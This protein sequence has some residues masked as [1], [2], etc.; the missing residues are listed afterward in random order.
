M[1]A[2][3]G[4]LAFAR[5]TAYSRPL[6][7]WRYVLERKPVAFEATVRRLM[8]ETSVADIFIE[9]SPWEDSTSAR[10]HRRWLEAVRTWY[11]LPDEPGALDELAYLFFDDV[12]EHEDGERTVYAD[13]PFTGQPGMF[14]NVH[15]VGHGVLTVAGVSHSVHPGDAYLLNPAIKHSWANR[16][17]ARCKAVSMVVPQELVAGLLATSSSAQACQFA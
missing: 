12:P 13:G 3:S 16:H 17:T 10:Y 2:D 15:Q 4:C 6:R 5:L 9:T 14:L 11:K 7:G 8:R 1:S